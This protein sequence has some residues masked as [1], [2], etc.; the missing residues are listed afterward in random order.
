MILEMFYY[1]ILYYHK[2]YLLYYHIELYVIGIK[3]VIV[4][5]LQKRDVFKTLF[6]LQSIHFFSTFLQ[7][8]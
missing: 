7:K 3:N 2:L 4:Q 1:I 8:N 5:N 6:F